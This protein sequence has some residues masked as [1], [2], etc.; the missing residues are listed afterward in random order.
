MI[1][2][3]FRHFQ[4][5]PGGRPLPSTLPLEPFGRAV[6]ERDPASDRRHRGDTG[7]TVIDARQSGIGSPTWM[8]SLY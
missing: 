8:L 3:L 1:D 2:E 6:T 5:P 7:D 4:V